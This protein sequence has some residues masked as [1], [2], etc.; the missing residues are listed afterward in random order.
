[1][2]EKKPEKTKSPGCGIIIVIILIIIIALSFSNRS[3]LRTSTSSVATT[4]SVTIVCADCAAAGM[5]INLWADPDRTSV[6]GSVPHGT[7]A[8][9]IDRTT[10]S[11]GRIVYRVRALGNSGWVTSNFI[12]R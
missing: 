7:S 6:V 4:Y 8:T 9:V 2:E 12:D 11:E 10:N 3:S 1:M 5:E